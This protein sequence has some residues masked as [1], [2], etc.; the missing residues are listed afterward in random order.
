MKFNSH[1]DSIVTATLSFYWPECDVDFIFHEIGSPFQGSKE[2]ETS[3]TPIESYVSKVLHIAMMETD[4][5]DL[6][7]ECRAS[8]AL[9]MG[10]ASLEFEI[11]SE[12]YNMETLKAIRK[13]TNHIMCTY[14][15]YYKKN[16]TVKS[17]SAAVFS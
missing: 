14:V 12:H 16:T 4:W 6:H 17:C 3:S 11:E 2:V 15:K 10:C 13:R 8:G 7:A 1:F 5:S 9:M